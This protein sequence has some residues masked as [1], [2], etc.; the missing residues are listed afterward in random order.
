MKNLIWTG[1]ARGAPQCGTVC[2]MKVFPGFEVTVT[3][4]ELAARLC[5]IGFE[6]VTSIDNDNEEEEES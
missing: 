2:G 5:V 3:D 6:E 4:D 1:K